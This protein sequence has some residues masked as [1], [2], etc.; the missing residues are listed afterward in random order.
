[1]NASEGCKESI[2]PGPPGPRKRAATVSSTE[3]RRD[4]DSKPGRVGEGDLTVGHGVKMPWL[5]YLEDLEAQATWWTRA[6]GFDPSPSGKSMSGW[7]RV[8]LISSAE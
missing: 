6:P 5:T 1:M 8:S 7:G 2:W 4:W 3:R